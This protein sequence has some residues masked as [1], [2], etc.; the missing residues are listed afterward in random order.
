[1]YS[2]CLIEAIKAKIK[3]PK[4]IKILKVNRIV[5][6]AGTHYMWYSV[7]DRTYSHF[8]WATEKH[9]RNWYKG[10][11]VVIAEK[12]FQRHLVER[13]IRNF[14]YNFSQMHE[15]LSS[16]K[17]EFV[18][19]PGAAENWVKYMEDSE[20]EYFNNTITKENY[21]V[22]LG[23]FG[24]KLPIKILTKDSKVSVV[25]FEEFLEKKQDI[26]KYKIITPLD[27]DFRGMNI[28][29]NSAK[30]FRIFSGNE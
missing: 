24:K 22:L 26:E 20:N 14:K 11:T 9:N 5:S 2:N 13:A 29:E 1:M 23:F 7:K 15:F 19:I 8:V 17:I 6:G 3:D 30:W 18:D 25:S 27:P 21:A 12:D 4:N 28:W 10:K 16:W